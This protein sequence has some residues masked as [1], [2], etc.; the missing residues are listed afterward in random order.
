MGAA[1]FSKSKKG[2]LKIL[3]YEKNSKKPSSF[4]WMRGSGTEPVFRIMCDVKGNDTKKE[5]DLLA[6]ETKMLAQADKIR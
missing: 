1:D 5:K 4:I 6:W 3:F 2:G